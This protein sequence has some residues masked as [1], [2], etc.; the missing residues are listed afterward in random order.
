LFDELKR[1]DAVPSIRCSSS[2]TARCVFACVVSAILLL[3]TVGACAAETKRVLM[4]H[5]FGRDFKP[6]SEY[7]RNIS[8]E[9]DQI[10]MVCAVIL[11]QS[12]LISWLLYQRWR[13]RSP[14]AGAP[15]SA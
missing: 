15:A 4:L 9:L 14:N 1:R 2:S 6:W 12:A 3:A 13:R 5:P 11:L 7:A 8:A 10:L